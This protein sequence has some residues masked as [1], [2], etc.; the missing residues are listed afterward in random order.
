MSDDTEKTW[1]IS[2][3]VAAVV[4]QID[5]LILSLTDEHLEHIVETI[6][7][8]KHNLLRYESFG[9]MFEPETHEPRQKLAKQSADRLRAMLLWRE[10][11]KTRD[12]AQAEA[13]A[14][15]AS[16]SEFKRKIGL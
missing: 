14:A 15:R 6:E 11:M 5:D 8:I 9:I 4:K 2:T 3:E 7:I 1:Q 13:L 10:C 12:D 16:T